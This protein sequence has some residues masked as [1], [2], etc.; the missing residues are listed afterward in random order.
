[1]KGTMTR[2]VS[3]TVQSAEVKVEAPGENGASH[4]SKYHRNT[5]KSIL[6][7]QFGHLFVTFMVTVNI[8]TMKKTKQT[9]AVFTRRKANSVR[10]II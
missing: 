7:G 2:H 6:N 10:L 8:N 9:K 4:P 1:M 5:F 3:V